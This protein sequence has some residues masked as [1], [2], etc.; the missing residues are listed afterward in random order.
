MRYIS[1]DFGHKN[2]LTKG[3]ILHGG[4]GMVENRITLSIFELRH[5]RVSKERESPRHFFTLDGTRL[6]FVKDPLF[7]DWYLELI[8]PWEGCTNTAITLVTTP[9]HY[10][11]KREW[12]ECPG[13][14]KRVGKVYRDVNDFRCRKCLDLVY[15]S[16]KENYHTIA[17]TIHKLVKFQDM[18]PVPPRFYKGKQTRRFGRYATLARK[19]GLGMN[20]YGPRYTKKSK[21]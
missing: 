11:G 7:H 16:Q 4:K 17:P 18:K 2:L 1:N 21:E 19:V 13:C 10:G 8:E 5:N 15:L 6:R 20:Y 12:F 9:C 3:L 14:K